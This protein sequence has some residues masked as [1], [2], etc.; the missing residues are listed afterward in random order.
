MAIF[1]DYSCLFRLFYVREFA[2]NNAFSL[3]SFFST[4]KSFVF[5]GKAEDVIEKKIGCKRKL[6]ANDSTSSFAAEVESAL[7]L[8]PVLN[9]RSAE[10]FRE[11]HDFTLTAGNPMVSIL[12]SKTMKSLG[13][14]EEAYC[15]FPTL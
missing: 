15:D 5:D 2:A 9:R 6:P 10:V 3:N 4:M 13:R 8:F 14:F 7:H 1:G 11:F 12:A